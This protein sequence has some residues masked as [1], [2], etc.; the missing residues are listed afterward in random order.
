[1]KRSVVVGVYMLKSL[2]GPEDEQG[3]IRWALQRFV[4]E[5]VRDSRA[6]QISMQ[7]IP[8]IIPSSAVKLPGSSPVTVMVLV[9]W[10]T[11]LS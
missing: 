11:I 6:G 1:M 8:L 9:V 10:A 7:V 2:D 5:E 3:S 4:A